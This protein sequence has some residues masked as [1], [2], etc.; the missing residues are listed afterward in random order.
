MN[1]IRKLL[2]PTSETNTLG[3]D[4]QRAMVTLVRLFIKGRPEFLHDLYVKAADDHGDDT[5]DDPGESITVLVSILSLFEGTND[6]GTKTETGRLAIEILRTYFSSSN[7]QRNAHSDTR[8]YD[9]VLIR[10]SSTPDNTLTIADTIAFIITQSQIQSQPHDASVTPTAGNGSVQA[11]AEAWFGLGLLSTL[12]S[13]RPWITSALARD[14]NR[15]L[16]RLKQIVHENSSKI[17]EGT[18]GTGLE[19]VH[20]MSSVSRDPRYG[21]VKVLV[22][23]MLQDQGTV[24]NSTDSVRAGLG[25]A[26]VEMGLV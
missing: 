19:M 18:S 2:K 24:T 17:V 13:A 15:L 26:A 14:Q 3:I 5:I 12:P 6:P 20:D 11:E 9:D 7:P 22:V 8:T 10:G 25:A 1:S 21:N 23:R 16:T 4:I